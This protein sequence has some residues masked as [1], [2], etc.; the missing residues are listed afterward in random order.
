MAT[1]L[2]K[3]S[4]ILDVQT[5]KFQNAMKRQSAQF[6]RIV[7]QIEARASEMEKSVGA[8]FGALGKKI[9]GA[10]AG[11]AVGSALNDIRKTADEYTKIINTLKVA[12]VIRAVR[13]ST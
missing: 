6:N 13:R 7:G 5:Q 4:L 11:I 12:G 8:S 9:A 3:L 2:E 10:F 1:D